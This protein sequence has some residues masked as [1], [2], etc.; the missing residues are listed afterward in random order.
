MAIGCPLNFINLNFLFGSSNILNIRLKS[1]IRQSSVY[2]LREGFKK[3]KNGKFGPLAENFLNPSPPSEFGP[4]YRL[5][6]I[7]LTFKG[8]N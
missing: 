1:S 8:P 4:S 5:S 2:L 3:T 7:V 6:L